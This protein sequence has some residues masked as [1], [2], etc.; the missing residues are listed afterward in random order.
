VSAI[1]KEN[2][3]MLV[4]MRRDNAHLKDSVSIITDLDTTTYHWCLTNDTI[5]WGDNIGQIQNLAPLKELNTG[6][7]FSKK[8]VTG[9]SSDR[10]EVIIN[11][12]SK[13]IGQG[14]PY[15]LTTI[16]G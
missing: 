15:R 8:I 1:R 14:V 5:T 3:E 13:D 11:S 12:P 6:S 2:D 16:I 7:L 9:K 10:A 4:A